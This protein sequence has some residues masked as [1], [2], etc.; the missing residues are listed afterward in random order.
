[1]Y[2]PAVPVLVPSVTAY[3]WGSLEPVSRTVLR[4][5]GELRRQLTAWPSLDQLQRCFGELTGSDVR[6][7]IRALKTGDPDQTGPRALELTLDAAVPVRLELDPALVSAAVGRTLG[8]APGVDNLSERVDPSLLG[9]MAALVSEALRRCGI[10]T[11]RRA[12][13][14]DPTGV[15][16]EMDATIVLGDS[17]YSARL[18]TWSA[19]P[20]QNRISAEPSLDGSGD[21][22]VQ[23]PLVVGAAWA[24]PGELESL[25]AGDAWLPGQGF[26]LDHQGAGRALLIAPDGEQGVWVDLTP[27]GRAVLLNQVGRLSVD[28]DPDCTGGAADM[29][30]SDDKLTSTLTSAVLDAPVA[31]RVEIGAISLT[32]REWAALNPGDVLQLGRRIG[33]PVVLRIAGREV[34]R[35]DLVNVEGEVGVRIR[36]LSQQAEK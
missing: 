36:E 11:A 6:I 34:A 9:A 12:R 35:G 22:M 32:V 5:W 30:K 27:E 1:V 33:D 21:V 15:A 2:Y 13:A 31:V 24:S 7:S 28:P 20:V 19:H 10:P 8:Q 16:L 14:P 4:S 3:P 23:L 18:W 25:G 29:S 17:A 26:W